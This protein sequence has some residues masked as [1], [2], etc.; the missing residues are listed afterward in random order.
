MAN[1]KHTV[2]HPPND[3]GLEKEKWAQVD[4]STLT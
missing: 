3:K 2:Y 4:L 1:M